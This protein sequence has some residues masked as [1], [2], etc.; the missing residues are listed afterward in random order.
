MGTAL[1]NGMKVTEIRAKAAIIAS[2][3]S[4]I[5]LNFAPIDDCPTLCR[6]KKDLAQKKIKTI[7][8]YHLSFTSKECADILYYAE[9]LVDTKLPFTGKKECRFSADMDKTTDLLMKL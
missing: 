7:K 3:G 2:A 4:R 5:V 1:S 9:R 8:P 6:Q